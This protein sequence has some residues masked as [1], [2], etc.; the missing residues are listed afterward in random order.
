MVFRRRDSASLS[1][2]MVERR[3]FCLFFLFLCFFVVLGGPLFLLGFG[4]FW[5]FSFCWF[6]LFFVLGD[7]LCARVFGDGSRSL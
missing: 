6:V 7:F 4:V 1:L 5:C 3:S 2:M